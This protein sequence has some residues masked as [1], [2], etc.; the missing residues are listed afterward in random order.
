MSDLPF[1]KHV[2]FSNYWP[3]GTIIGYFDCYNNHI[4]VYGSQNILMTGKLN[5]L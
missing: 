3:F 5:T 1:V 2:E 4:H